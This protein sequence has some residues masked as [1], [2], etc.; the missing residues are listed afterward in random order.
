MEEAIRMANE[1]IEEYLESL[2]QH[3]DEI[4]TEEGTL[5][6]TLMVETHA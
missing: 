6:Y 5:E 4:P 1:A 3:G 2:R